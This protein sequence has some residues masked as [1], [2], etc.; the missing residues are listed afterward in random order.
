[1]TQYASIADLTSLGFPALAL[2]SLPDADANNAL[3]AASIEA[4]GY[5]APRYTLPLTTWPLSLRM[6]VARIAAYVIMSTRGMNPGSRGNELIVKGYDDAIMWLKNVAR[7]VVTLPIADTAAPAMISPQVASSY[8]R[9]WDA[10]EDCL[11]G[12]Y[13]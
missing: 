7:G 12:G 5:L 8:S 10:D 13:L 1:M 4:D 6:H 2:G 9:G 11:D 3:D